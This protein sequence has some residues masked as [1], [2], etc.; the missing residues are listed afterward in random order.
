[1][2]E[3]GPVKKKGDI[4]VKKRKVVIMDLL[5]PYPSRG[6]LHAGGAIP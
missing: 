1:M 3:T 5:M 6:L 4:H 2:E